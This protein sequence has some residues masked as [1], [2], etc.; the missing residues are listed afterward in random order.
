MK[1]SKFSGEAAHC[2][3]RSRAVRWLSKLIRCCHPKG[4]SRGSM[5]RIREIGRR[6]RSSSSGRIAAHQRMRIGIG[7]INTL[8]RIRAGAN[9][10]LTISTVCVGSEVGDAVR[11]SRTR[12][13]SS[14][15]SRRARGWT[16]CQRA[17]SGSSCA[18]KAARAAAV[19][20]S[21]FVVV[22]PIVHCDEVRDHSVRSRTDG[23]V[24]HV[25]RFEILVRPRDCTGDRVQ[26]T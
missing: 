4:L 2:P 23:V 17:V 15:A 24:P 6:R 21:A 9:I 25:N 16:T 20:R 13:V 26:A 10:Q 12:K 22:V 3:A 18:R 5:H 1:P 11:A 19:P 7:L 14:A 8:P